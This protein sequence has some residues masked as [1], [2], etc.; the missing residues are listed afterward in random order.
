MSVLF[1]HKINW[2]YAVG[3]VIL[4]FVGIT[5]AIAFD[6]W[7]EDRKEKSEK[8]RLGAEYIRSL[9]TSIRQ[10]AITFKGWA[11]SFAL[12]EEWARYVG[13]ILESK[14]RKIDDSLKFINH[15]R[16][17]SLHFVVRQQPLV[18]NELIRSGNQT[19]IEDRLL[20]SQLHA[21]Y[22]DHNGFFENFFA[23]PY[24]KRMALRS[25]DQA[26]FRI[27]ENADYT[28]DNH[29]ETLPSRAT[30]EAIL[31]DPEILGLIRSI[32]VSS[33]FQSKFLRDTLI[34][35]AEKILA[36]MEATYPELQDLE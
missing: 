3:E 13:Y 7:N 21:Y 4:I 9:Y 24:E 29:F 16:D 34:E 8:V 15:Y 26:L 12:Q 1:K 11:D 28:E 32:V 2:Q 27:D 23:V 33:G 19:L 22:N 30:Y 14:N 17:A 6:N 20:M 25:I 10:D 18:W 5:M 36:Y 35:D 31:K